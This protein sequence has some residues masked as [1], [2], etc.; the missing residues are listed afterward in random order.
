MDNP[1]PALSHP[2]LVA[3]TT[4]NDFVAIEPR[5]ELLIRALVAVRPSP[6]PAIKFWDLHSQPDAT[7]RHVVM[8]ALCD[9]GSEPAV[10]L[11][12]KKLIGKAYE[13]EERI[14]WMRDPLLRHRNDVPLLKV[15]KRMITASLEPPL[16]PFLVESLFDYRPDEWYVDCTP[17]RPP[18]LLAATREAKTLVLEIATFILDANNKITLEPRTRAVVEAKFKLLKPP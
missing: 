15:C 13:E 12:E 10:D 1:K 8:D 14:A 6:P 17:P 9:N 4:R 11:F 3:L 5:Q 7:W 2:I 18:E 16:K